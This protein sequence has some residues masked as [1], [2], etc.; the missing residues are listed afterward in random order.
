MRFTTS[1]VRDQ[2]QK[3]PEIRKEVTMKPSTKILSAL[4][5]A[6][7]LTASSAFAQIYTID[8][9]G[10]SS[11]PNITPG[12]MQLDPSGGLTIPVLV[13]NLPFPVITGDVVLSEPGQPTG[14][15]SDIVRFWDPTGAG[16]SQI[17]FYSDVSAADPADAP[18]DT[19]L[20]PQLSNRVIINEVGP[21]GN[22]GAIY[23]PPAGGPGSIPG[24]VGLQYNIISDVPEPSTVALV[25][26]GVGLLLVTLKPRPQSNIH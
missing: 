4:S 14:T 3:K 5:C 26:E 24:A 12:V 15:F 23:V 7:A 16:P 11:G 21:E 20:P 10:N 1:T 19:G 2:N 9:F 22:N 25:I 18:A 6:C 13:Y 17:I 8:E